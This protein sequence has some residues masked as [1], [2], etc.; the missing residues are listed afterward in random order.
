MS[1]VPALL[2]QGRESLE[3]LARAYFL[4]EVTGQARARS[5]V[6]RESGE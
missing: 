1:A 4:A 5:G 3:A 2:D 6:V